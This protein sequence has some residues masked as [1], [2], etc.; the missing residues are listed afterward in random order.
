MKSL[1]S[2]GSVHRR[3]RGLQMRRRALEMRPVGQHRQ[4]GGAAV[5]D[6]RGRARPGRSPARISPPEGEAFLI[7]AIRPNRPAAA[8]SFSASPKPRG[9]A[10]GDARWLQG[11]QRHGGL[12]PRHFGARVGADPGEHVRHRLRSSGGLS[13][14]M[15]SSRRAASPARPAPRPLSIDARR[16]RA[17]RRAE[18]SARPATISAAAA[19]SSTVSRYG[20]GAPRNNASKRRG[21][22]R[23]VAAA[24]GR[25]RR[26]RQ[27]G[28]L[29]RRR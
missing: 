29:R 21:V 17:P 7:S 13:S 27:P 26:A 20:P 9:G 19:F 23:R 24:D 16:L 28:L 4:A 25:D 8:A 2:T 10:G 22:R 14:I 5:R 18:S 6:R 15:R 3:A 12:A 1:R 11:L